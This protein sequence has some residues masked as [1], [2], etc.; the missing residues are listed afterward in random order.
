MTDGDTQMAVLLRHLIHRVPGYPS[1]A[2]AENS[3]S[4]KSTSI[5]A[6]IADVRLY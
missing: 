2:Y 1:P 3:G 4:A 6:Q 5:G